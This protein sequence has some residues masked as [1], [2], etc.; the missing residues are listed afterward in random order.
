MRS[1]KTPAPALLGATLLVFGV[2]ACGMFSK[3]TVLDLIQ[4]AG[5]NTSAPIVTSNLAAA[6]NNAS[7]ATANLPS[8]PSSLDEA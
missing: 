6:N 1:M 3:A 8:A 2:A 4:L 7:T 5:N